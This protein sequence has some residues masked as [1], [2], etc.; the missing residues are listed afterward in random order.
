VEVLQVCVLAFLDLISFAG[1]PRF[2][3]GTT[4]G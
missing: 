2:A 4:Q 1:R 3:V